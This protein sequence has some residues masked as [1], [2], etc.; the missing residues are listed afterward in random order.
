MNTIRPPGSEQEYVSNHRVPHLNFSHLGICVRDMEVMEDFYTRV[1]GMTVTDRGS[2]LDT[3]LVF[4]SRDPAEHHQIVLGTGRPERIPENTSNPMFGA[5]INQISFRIASLNGL[6]EFDRH[7]TQSHTGEFIYA[8]HGTAWSIY[9]H[10][11]E[12]NMLE[13]FVDSEW[14][15]KQPVFE[16][17][18]LSQTNKEILQKTRSLCEDAGEGFEPVAQ[19]RQRIEIL[20]ELQRI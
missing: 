17:L 13:A 19:W 2:A 11:P 10:D 18:D 5:I 7:L 15:I 6:K 16:P 1:L 3:D 8:N 12:G 14:Y 20:M 9:F 4:L